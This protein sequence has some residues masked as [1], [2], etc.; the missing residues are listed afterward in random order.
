MSLVATNNKLAPLVFLTGQ[1]LYPDRTSAR[2]HAPAEYFRIDA[3]GLPSA[4]IKPLGSFILMNES[5]G[6]IETGLDGEI[7]TMCKHGFP[8]GIY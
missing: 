7:Y 6:Q 1:E 2:Q 5:T 4:E 3:A 8:I